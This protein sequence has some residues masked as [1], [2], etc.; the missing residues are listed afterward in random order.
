VLYKTMFVDSH[1]HL[2]MESFDADRDEVIARSLTE[3]L[4]YILTVGTEARYFDK[5][6]ELIEK[7]PCV[8]GAIGIHPHNSTDLDEDLIG[9]IKSL[10]KHRKIVAYGE[11]GLDFFRNYSPKEAQIRAFRRQ[12]ELAQKAKVPVIIHSRDAREET[13]GILEE[14][15]DGQWNGVI[16]C[17]S[18]DVNTAR[19]LLDMGFHISIPGT[20]TYKNNGYQADV[21]RFVPVDRLLAETDAPFLTP[22]PFRGK[23]NEPCR[24]KLT[25]S[26]M[27]EIKQMNLQDLASVM[28]RNFLDLFFEGMEEN[29]S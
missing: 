29:K 12:I 9:R 2:E 17:Y 28:Y 11:I 18:Y 3:G 6:L 27:A 13:L 24:V 19:R 21:V 14:M 4:A 10:L 16:H 1:C 23:R 26:R 7:H 20:V 25:V 5:V 8:Y 15:G 22:N